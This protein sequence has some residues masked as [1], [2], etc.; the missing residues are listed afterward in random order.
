MDDDGDD[1]D[2]STVFSV[3]RKEGI[4]ISNGIVS[5]CFVF[6]FIYLLCT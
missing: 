5:K 1:V 2:E 4:L 6:V 3:S